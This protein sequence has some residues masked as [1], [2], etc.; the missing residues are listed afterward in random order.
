MRKPVFRVSL[1]IVSLVLA[2]ISGTAQAQ[3]KPG[4]RQTGANVAMGGAVKIGQKV[5]NDKKAKQPS[6]A[7]AHRVSSPRSYSSTPQQPVFR[8]APLKPTP[9]PTPAPSSRK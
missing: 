3:S 5:V 7:H 8:R 4:P 2:C 1:V 6:L 9:K